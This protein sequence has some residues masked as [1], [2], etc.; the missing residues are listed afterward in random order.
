MCYI[1][2]LGAQADETP[3]PQQAAGESEQEVVP[4]E[5][6]SRSST[7]SRHRAQAVTTSTL[8]SRSLTSSTTTTGHLEDF[9]EQKRRTS[10][11]TAHIC[12]TKHQ[13]QDLSTQTRTASSVCATTRQSGQRR[14]DTSLQTSHTWC[15]SWSGRKRL[16][17]RQRRL[18]GHHPAVGISQCGLSF[19]IQV[20]HV[21]YFS[22]LAISDCSL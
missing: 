13:Y 9:E 22:W 7:M 18:G 19:I 16:H 17:L 5:Q 2:R 15:T 10:P 21:I 4:R 12:L 6:T 3:L 8:T 1:A 11:S 20:F 14:I